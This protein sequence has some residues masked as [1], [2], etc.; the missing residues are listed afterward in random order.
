VIRIAISVEAFEAISATLPLGTVAFEPELNAK[1]ER[2]VWLENAMADRLGAMRG[3]WATK[4]AQWHCGEDR[5]DI[6]SRWKIRVAAG[7]DTAC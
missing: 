2:F 7:E 6:W 5:T 4:D 3:Y 1:G